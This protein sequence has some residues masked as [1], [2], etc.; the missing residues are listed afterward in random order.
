[1]GTGFAVGG[2]LVLFGIVVLIVG[3]GC[4]DLVVKMKDLTDERNVR[5]RHKTDIAAKILFACG[6]LLCLG[7]IAAALLIH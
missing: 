3:N 5:N 6:G 7:G 1:M 2:T 4:R